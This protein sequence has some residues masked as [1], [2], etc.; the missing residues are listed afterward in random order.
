MVLGRDFWHGRT[1]GWDSFAAP[2]KRQIKEWVARFMAGLKWYEVAEYA[3]MALYVAS[4]PIHWRLGVLALALVVISAVVKMVASGR[5][6][7]RNLPQAFG[8]CLW[9]MVLYYLLY[10]VSIYYSKSPLD[11][12]SAVGKKLP[13][14]I[15]PLFFLFSDLSYIRRRHVSALSLLLALVLT[16]RFGIMLVQAVLDLMA[17]EAYKNVIQSHFDPMHY[18]YLALYIVT[19]I[20]LLFFEAMR[21]WRLP[22]WRKRRWAL[23]GD[24]VVMVEYILILGSRSGLLTMVMI[25]AAIAF[26]LVL[27]KKYKAGTIVALGFA[28]LLGLNRLA[29][30]ELFSRAESTIEKL[31]KGEDGDVREEIWECGLN[32]VEDHEIVG[33]GNVGYRIGLYREYINH[34]LDSSYKHK[35]NLHNQYLETLLSTGVVGLVVMLVMVVMPAIVSLTRKYWN[36]ATVVFSILYAAWIFFEEGFSRQMGLLFICWWYCA[37]L[38]FAR[39]YPGPRVEMAKWRR[40]PKAEPAPPRS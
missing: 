32:L 21:Y 23:V 7:N 10:F 34:D 12:F 39:C 4:V 38:A 13:A 35:L 15:I 37:L 33:Y 9:V 11:G 14:I 26:Y 2:D 22:K 40:R 29:S 25:V 28:L 31:E 17:G 19:A 8:C 3:A 20:I 27:A 1:I 36:P 18:N 16:V 6:V 30:P 5:V 24:M